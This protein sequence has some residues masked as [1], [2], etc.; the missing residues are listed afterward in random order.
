MV[1]FHRYVSL[2]NSWHIEIV[3]LPFVKIVIFH[4]CA[5]LLNSWHIEIVDL[6]FLKIVIFHRYVSLP[7]STHGGFSSTPSLIEVKS[8]GASRVT[9][10]GSEYQPSI[11]GSKHLEM[12][13]GCLL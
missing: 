11:F 10:H 1:I 7:E 8:L 13:V 12:V 5:S 3:D 6:P 4:R 9:L 2:L